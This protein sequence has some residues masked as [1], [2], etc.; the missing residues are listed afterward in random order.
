M[1][2]KIEFSFLTAGPIFGL[3]LPDDFEP[4]PE[5]SSPLTIDNGHGHRSYDFV[6]AAFEPAISEDNRLLRKMADREG[7]TVEFYERPEDPPQ[8]YLR[9]LLS[10]GALYTH[11]RE[12]EGP[13]WAPII[14]ANLT[15]VERGGMPPVLLPEPPLGRGASSRAGYHERATFASN[16]GN[17]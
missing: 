9:W 11:L 2:R 4:V 13:E 7:R 10:N 1:A 8:W 14:V 6:P 3:E 17:D 12:A 16:R 15:I 5:T